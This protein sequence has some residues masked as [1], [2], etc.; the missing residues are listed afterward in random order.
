MN[1]INK[2][3]DIY[4]NLIFKRR[5]RKG[6]GDKSREKN[7]IRINSA[8]LL[9]TQRSLRLVFIGCLIFIVIIKTT[10]IFAE[11]QNEGL[12]GYTET[13]YWDKDN[14]FNGYTLFA[15]HGKTY[16]I[17][18]EGYLVNTWNS[19]TNPRFLENG[20]ILDASKDDP[21]RFSGFQELDWDGNV[22]WEYTESRE[23]Y[24]PHHDFVRIYNKKLG[25][26][27]TLFI[28][29]K[30]ISSEEALQAGADPANA[31]YK[32]A[33][34]DVI[35]EVDMEGNVIWEWWFFDHVVQD[36][37]PTKDNYVESI[38]DH[39]ERININLPGRQLKRDWLHCNS[40]D[41]NEDLDQIVT[42]SVQGEF[43]V[44]DHGNTFIPNDSDSSIALA[45]SE[46]GDFLYRFG[47]PARYDQGDPP[48][49][50]DD[51]T[52]VS[53]GHKQIGGAHDVQWIKPGLPGEGHFLIFNNGQYLYET[54]SQSYIHEINSFLDKNGNNTGDYVNP[55]D[56]GYYTLES[57][58]DTQKAKRNISNQIVWNYG[59]Y[60]N[61]SF[62]SH[63]GSGAQRLPNGNTLICSDTE[64]H[65]FEVTDDSI[66][67][68]EY[69]SPVLKDEIL[70]I[71]YDNI[72]MTNSVFR[73]YRYSADHPALV[74]KDLEP[75]TTITGRT[76]DY[77]TPEGHASEIESDNVVGEFSLQQNYPNPFN[78]S[79][80][81]PY[82]I[83]K[84][85]QIQLHIYDIQ[86]SKIKSLVDSHQSAGSYQVIWDSTNDNGNPVTS[87]LYFIRL[88]NG[89][90]TKIRK[91][92]LVR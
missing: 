14:A 19:G 10:M 56:A 52:S 26:Y 2:I 92:V 7:I 75:I 29:N 28:A 24:Y 55:P 46:L 33:Q 76:P 6:Q 83:V 16:L 78:P 79:T 67:V 68:W 59:S 62:F 69:I 38:A 23:N 71:L 47:D 48:S 49:I 21:S 44:I 43:Y 1:R 13:R 41:Y 22:V 70:E 37:D 35:V 18:M 64:G 63:I 45:E 91:V 88:T 25:D 32:N 57:P 53:S 54:T 82:K 85:S 17:D 31:P 86:G 12:V 50:S 36:V 77:I 80:N 51:W 15:G 65:L 40:L 5:D 30:D 8:V 9:C 58:K 34:M 42:N 27:T 11:T 73:A 84:D 72:P 87:G 20:N 90:N 81:I 74:G 66:L 39:P 89:N 4:K 61:Q 60:S 3:M